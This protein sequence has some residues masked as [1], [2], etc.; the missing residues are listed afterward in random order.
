MR[1]KV[2]GSFRW[3]P[4]SNETPAKRTEQLQVIV[5][6]HHNVKVKSDHHNRFQFKQ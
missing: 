5:K 6:I 3:L 2:G 4:A 1:D